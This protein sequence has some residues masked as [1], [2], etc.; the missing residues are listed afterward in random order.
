MATPTAQV[1]PGAP[2]RALVETLAVAKGAY[3]RLKTPLVAVSSVGLLTLAA[4]G[5]SGSS[6]GGIGDTPS[7]FNPG[8]TGNFQDP[9]AKGPVTISSAQKGGTVTVLTNLGFTTTIDP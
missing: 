7:N 8:A 4:C 3:M 1:S 5:G 2:R 9:H 6:S